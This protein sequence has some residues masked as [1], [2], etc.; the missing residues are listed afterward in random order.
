MNMNY[1]MDKLAK[2]YEQFY[3][4]AQ[5]YMGHFSNGFMNSLC[6]T[7]KINHIRITIH[8]SKD[9]DISNYNMRVHV[10]YIFEYP[11]VDMPI[12]FSSNNQAITIKK[13]YIDEFLHEDRN[14]ILTDW[15][16]IFKEWN[17]IK[18]S[19]NRDLALKRIEMLVR[20]NNISEDFK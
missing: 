16:M 20:T 14:Q 4:V 9:F 17:E 8:S 7:D 19:E 13:T 15:A 12:E 5:K 6:D 11:V 10:S 3:N 18:C 2:D 1:E